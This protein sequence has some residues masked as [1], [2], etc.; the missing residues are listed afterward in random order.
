MSLFDAPLAE[1][2]TME[3]QRYILRRN[4]E[5]ATEIASSRE[6]KYRVLNAAT[7]AA[8]EYLASHPR[9]KP[10]TQLKNL[11]SRATKLRISGWTTFNL[12]GRTITIGKDADA[13][14]EAS[15]L[16]AAMS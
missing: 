12:E 16:D 15:K 13:L 14:A 4:P 7:V 5:C 2:T 9:A 11:Q 1:A 8:N 3:G 6:S 10:S